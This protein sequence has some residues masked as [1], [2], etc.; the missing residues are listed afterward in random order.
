MGLVPKDTPFLSNQSCKSVQCPLP[1]ANCKEDR[2]NLK[3]LIVNVNKQKDALKKNEIT[4]DGVHYAVRFKV[5][6]DLKALN[7]LL[8]QI[9]KANFQLGKR[10]TE[11][12]CCFICKA[13]RKCNCNLGLHTI[14]PTTNKI[15]NLLFS[16][17]KGIRDDLEFLFEEDLSSINLCTLHCELRN[18]EQLLS[19][20]VFFCTKWVHLMYVMPNWQIMALRILAAE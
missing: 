5:I 18:T 3:K 16:C 11:V 2:E 4:V 15:M 12:E 6:L 14:S 10:G 20:L 7:L 13:L 19:L 9:G 1:I 17:F 8:E